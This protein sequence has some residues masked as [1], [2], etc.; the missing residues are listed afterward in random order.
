MP[1]LKDSYWQTI[2]CEGGGILAVS[3]VLAA[4]VAKGRPVCKWIGFTSWKERW[5]AKPISLRGDFLQRI[6]Q[7]KKLATT[8]SATSTI[9]PDAPKTGEQPVGLAE[10]LIKEG[11]V[12]GIYY[13]KSFGVKNLL[14]QCEQHHKGCN[15]ALATALNA[16]SI[17][18]NGMCAP[19]SRTG[20][21]LPP[22]LE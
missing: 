12:D 7:W 8:E 10:D 3:Q 14:G 15:A 17:N 19:I 5:K 16:F 13:W 11:S 9:D 22:S 2:L 21:P 20:P 18:G 6:L 4:E 1:F